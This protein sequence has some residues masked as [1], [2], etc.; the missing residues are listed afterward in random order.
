MNEEHLVFVYDLLFTRF[1]ILK[2]NLFFFFRSIREKFFYFFFGLFKKVK[3]DVGY[4]FD[5]IVIGIVEEDNYVGIE[6][7][8][9]IL[10][11]IFDFIYF[12]GG[13]FMLFVYGDVEFRFNFF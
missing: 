9:K 3:N 6:R 2:L 13:N 5:D 7:I 4:K 10:L 1:R 12:K 8:D 11:V